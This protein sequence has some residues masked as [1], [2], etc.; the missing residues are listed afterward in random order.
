[1]HLPHKD[2]DTAAPDSAAATAATAPAASAFVENDINVNSSGS[3]MD[4]ELRT[5]VFKS[6]LAA[7][8]S[9]DKGVVSVHSS[10][11]EMDHFAKQ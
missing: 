10:D 9:V 7:P 6:E 1:M 5:F 8:A 4:Q 3:E 11:S 2:A